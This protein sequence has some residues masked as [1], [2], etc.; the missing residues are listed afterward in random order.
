M[1]YFTDPAELALCCGV[2]AKEQEVS[3]LRI[4]LDAAQG[5]VRSQV[6]A[7]FQVTSPHLTDLF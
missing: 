5:D 7:A 3:E 2:Q 6:R 1:S 4:K